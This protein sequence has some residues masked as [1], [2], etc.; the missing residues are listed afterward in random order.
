MVFGNRGARSSAR[1]QRKSEAFQPRGEALEEK[2]L[3]A[4]LQLGAGTPKNIAG[5]QTTAPNGPQTIGGQ[6][7]YIADSSGFNP[8]TQGTQTTDPGLGILQTGNVI[9]QGAGY[10][11]AALGDMNLDGNND[12]LI[13]AP[14]VTQSGSV[15]SP[16]TTAVSTAYLVFGNRSTSLP[17][18]QSWLSA[19]PEQRVGAL[20]QLGG[21][22]QTNPF[23]GRGQ[24]YNYNF[25]GVSFITSKSPNSELGA[26]VAQAGPNAFVIGA[27]DY[28]G[29]GRLYYITATSN[30][31]LATLTS[32][33]IDL[34]NPQNY[35][36]LTI[37]T[38]EDT[39]FPTS[40]LG[41]SFADVPNVFGDGADT[42]AI[43]EPVLHSTARPATAAFSSSR[44]RTCRTFS[45][46]ITSFRS[47]QRRSSPFV[48]PIAATRP[49]TRSPTPAT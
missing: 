43:G 6:L 35:P 16:G 21:S 28:S 12:F 44:C 40:G 34:D 32:A 17:T 8:Q 37:V 23:T 20:S 30:F 13:G 2:V 9:S 14:G 1:K 25:A 15:I 5:N 10:T 48:V 47:S 33:P 24:P 46:G 11:V 18:I 27:P 36:G 45:V 49:G 26:F 7:P 22:I 19:T 38:F 42:I 3:L 31:N 4:L 41:T 39:A 29:G